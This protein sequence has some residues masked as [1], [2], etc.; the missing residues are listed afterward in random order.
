M[1]K[2]FISLFLFLGVN[3]IVSSQNKKELTLQEI[4]ASPTFRP[5]MVMG[6][7]PMQDGKHYSTLSFDDSGV[8]IG[9][10]SYASGEKVG[11]IYTA[12]SAKLPGGLEIPFDDY[13]LSKD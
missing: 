4:W 1:H 10:Y 7:A 3:S 8:S 9:K 13:T 5:E 11:D 2:H 12:N 6:V